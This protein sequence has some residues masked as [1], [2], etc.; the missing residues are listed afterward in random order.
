MI[1]NVYPLFKDLPPYVDKSKE[2]KQHFQSFPMFVNKV[3]EKFGS[4]NY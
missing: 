4:I 2:D 3:R 1:E